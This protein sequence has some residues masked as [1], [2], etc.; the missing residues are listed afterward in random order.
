MVI[1]ALAGL[2]RYIVYTRSF[3]ARVRK[4]SVPE[5]AAWRTL[6]VCGVTEL[7]LC[8]ISLLY[9]FKFLFKGFSDTLSDNALVGPKTEAKLH[10]I[11]C[12]LFPSLCLLLTRVFDL[13]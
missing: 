9:L 7:S 10:Y 2:M 6:L 5:K 1:I 13:L 8:L 11:F 3:K 4:G 12:A